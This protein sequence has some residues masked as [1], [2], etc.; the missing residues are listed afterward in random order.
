M[1]RSSVVHRNEIA[2]FALD[3]AVFR[4]KGGGYNGIRLSQRD[5]DDSEHKEEEAHF[6]GCWS[7]IYFLVLY[8]FSEAILK[9]YSENII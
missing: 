5:G 3:T 6:S 4:G 1:D 8:I 9:I 2:S 7:Y